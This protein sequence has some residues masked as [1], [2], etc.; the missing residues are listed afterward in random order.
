MTP[1]LS[2]RPA[3]RPLADLDQV[4]WA[5]L[6][7]CYGPATE[8]P[9]QLRD[10]AS[11][12]EEARTRAWDRLWSNLY[13]QGNVYEATAHAVPFLLHL[14]TDETTPHRKGFLGYLS[15]LVTG[16]DEG[17]WFPDGYDSTM[18]DG[19]PV[20][21][22]VYEAVEAGIP[23]VVAP[24]LDHDD[25][26]TATL[27]AVLTAWFPSAAPHVLPA[28]RRLCARPLPRPHRATALLVLGLLAGAADDRSDTA[29]LERILQDGDD[30]D[31]WA[32]AV[33][34]ARISAPGLP[35]TAIGALTDELGV[36]CADPDAYETVARV[37]FCDGF[38]AEP[39]LK[40]LRR[41]PEAGRETARAC[42]ARLLRRTEEQEPKPWGT[43]V[44]LAGYALLDV[45]RPT[46]AEL[47]PWQ[48]AVLRALLDGDMI[49]TSGEL[50]LLLSCEHG[51]PDTPDAL[52]AWLSRP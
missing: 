36:I 12:D 10:L 28:L 45:G 35:A 11:P 4:P 21:S 34:L 25:P 47:T 42:L 31:R 7:H 29:R 40:T 2:G 18:L 24:L 30:P 14:L 48:H 9:S 37:I 6:A 39:V 41:L 8:V 23:T 13:H 32:A 27:A 19:R 15:V 46:A 52:E 51:I 38:V 43:A 49:W 16:E 3:T 1:G 20:E 44:T 33:A 5:G 50:G 22:A 17:R 26:E